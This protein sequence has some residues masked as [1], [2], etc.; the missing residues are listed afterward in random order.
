MELLEP[1]TCSLI[2]CYYVK[3]TIIARHK[4]IIIELFVKCYRY[5]VMVLY[6]VEI[7]D[8]RQNGCIVQ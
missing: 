8:E 3:V 7:E 2:P 6:L 5:K 4:N 1:W